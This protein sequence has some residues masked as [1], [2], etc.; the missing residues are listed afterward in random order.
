MSLTL[1]HTSIMRTPITKT[2]YITCI[3]FYMIM[4]VCVCVCAVFIGR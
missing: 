1:L 4:D 2:F 3:M